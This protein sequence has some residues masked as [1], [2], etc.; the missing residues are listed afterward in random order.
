MLRTIIIDDEEHQRHSIAKMLKLFCPEAEFSGSADSLKS[1]I[2]I[3]RRLKPDLVLLD[4][5]LGDGTGFDLLT[6]LSPVDFRVIFITAY[7]EYAIRA[8][9]FSAL[10]Y[11]LKPVD[12][13][14][15]AGSVKRASRNLLSVFTEQ[16]SQLR[17]H[18]QHGH[19]GT[20]K[21]VVRTFESIHLVVVSDILYCQSD[22]NYTTLHL[23]GQPDIIASTLLKEYEE[24]LSP[25]GFFR[26]HKSYL[27]NLGYISRFD[28]AEGGYVVLTDGSRVPVASRK[29][30]VLLEM[31]NRLK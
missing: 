19:E 10:D 16:L 24:L 30:E 8:F 6:Q 5:R 23:A 26:I 31:F 29:R 18:L 13:E 9:R 11:L 7:D 21:I 22:G 1:G 12:P 25:L 20:R 17:E 27:I 3:I 2:E 15:L 4:V 28:K 14:E